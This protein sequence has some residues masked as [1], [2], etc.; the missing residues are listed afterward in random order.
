[1][2]HGGSRVKPGNVVTW[3][4]YR[5]VMTSGA[6]ARLGVAALEVHGDSRLARAG[7]WAARNWKARPVQ[8]RGEACWGRSWFS[9][10]SRTPLGP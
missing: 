8:V 3:K 6:V 4:G 5:V 2:R 7:R 1:M 10:N 9:D